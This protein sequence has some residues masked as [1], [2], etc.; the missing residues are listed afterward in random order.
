MSQTRRLIIAVAILV[1][2]VGIVLGVDALRGKSTANSIDITVEAGDI[3]IYVSG[4][5]LAA[6]NG[7]D[8]N[9]IQQ[10]QF[11]DKE[12][13]KTQEGWLVSSVFNQF[14]ETDDFSDVLQ[15]VFT[16]SSR[17]KSITLTWEEIR[18]PDNMVLFD[19]SGRGTLKLV[20][21]LER[22]DTREEWIQDVD[23]IE[24]IEP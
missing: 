17:N 23:K 4:E 16:S 12:E 24:V 20:S 3:P 19:L 18:N 5:L 10:M 8:L 1:F 7:D 14:F 15:I 21:L 6:F 2:L 11:I 13:G 22:L 9:D